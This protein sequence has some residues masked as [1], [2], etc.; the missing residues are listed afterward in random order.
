M[1]INKYGKILI[2]LTGNIASGK[3]LVLK[4]FDNRLFEKIDSDS[5]ARGHLLKLRPS[6]LPDNMP[7]EEIF[8]KRGKINKDRLSFIAFSERE[9]MREIEK[10]IHPRTINDIEKILKNQE[11]RFAIIESA[12]L[13]ESGLDGFFDKVITVFAPFE[14]RLRR[15]MKR[16]GIDRT[17]AQKRIDFQMDEYEKVLRSDFVI[18]NSKDKD[19]L[20][21][22][23]SNIE[24]HLRNLYRQTE[25]QKTLRK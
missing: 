13:F 2:G 5:I 21:R 14:T 6:D 4:L 22:Q 8:S 25:H 23:V 18:D 11:K 10:V 20:K 16:A 1:Q 24:E 15:L 3:S 9:I 12:L 19:W 7:I 17:E